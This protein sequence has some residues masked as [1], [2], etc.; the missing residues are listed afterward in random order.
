MTKVDRVLLINPPFPMESRYGKG[1][2]KIG[3]V[4][5]SLG[6][7]YV[8][9]ALEQRGYA[10][11]I[12]DSPAL[13]LDIV[14]TVENIVKERPDIVGLTCLTP[15]FD[16]CLTLAEE[17]KRQIDVEVMVGG[18][19][20]TLFPQ[21][22]VENRS[23]DYAIIGEG[24]ITTP[25][26]LENLN[27]DNK[28]N[29][30]KG[31]A[32]K[33]SNRVILNQYRAP[34]EDIDTIAFPARHLLPLELYRPAP[35]EYKR[36]PMM[37]MVTSRGC[38][39]SCTF[40]CARKMWEQRYRQRSVDN[41]IEEINLLIDKYRVRDISFFDEILGLRKSWID[42]F[43]DKLISE[44]LNLVWSCYTR[45]DII[46]RTPPE[47]LHKMAKAGCW[48]FFFGF[49]SGCQDL[50]DNINKRITL[51]QIRDAVRLTKKAGIEVLANFMLALPGETPEK[52]MKTIRLAVELD[53]E[54]AKFNV[55][56]P[57]PGT[58]LY[59]QI[60][61]GEW[62]RLEGDRDKY[63]GYHPVFI[64]NGYRDAKEIEEVKRKAY[65]MFYLRPSYIF[66]G[67]FRIRSYEDI[68]RNIRGFRAVMKI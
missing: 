22:V 43:C 36:L 46:S 24:E 10:V 4:L 60:T 33:D 34:I 57:H 51:Q 15:N 2:E 23:V 56:T 21:Q 28:L 55:T 3:A 25:E 12:L 65:R 26:L 58:E 38:P 67:G 49:E 62:G 42:E 29:E 50:L 40:C 59:E 31:I 6:L 44:N 1:L 19:H 7:A 48:L 37:T 5:P 45:A 30:V 61:N 9:A 64:P 41:V 18:P 35:N 17:I 16:L 14:N 68:V 53:P 39:Y 32:Y 11:K 47:L 27:T 66:R 13:N 52:A 20:A 8:A 54:I 63:T